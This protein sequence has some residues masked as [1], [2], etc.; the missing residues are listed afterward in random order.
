MSKL[1]AAQSDVVGATVILLTCLYNDREFVKIGYYVNND[2]DKEE[3]NE[4]DGRPTTLQ[5]DHL[6]RN[7]LAEKPRVTRTNIQWYN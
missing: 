1:P 3:W 7:I 6:R 2:Y 4:E 5:V